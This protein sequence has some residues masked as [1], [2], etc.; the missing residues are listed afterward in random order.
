M[1]GLLNRLPYAADAPFN[2]YK[3]Q[4]DTT[5]LHNTRVDLLRQIYDWIDGA[6]GR[7]IFWLNGLAGTG[8][9]TIARTVARQC[10][11]QYRLGASF[12]FSRGG[13][14]TGHA[15][16]FFTSLALQLARKSQYLKR[17]ICDAIENSDIASQSLSEQWRQLIL[18]PLSK[19]SSSSHPSS[20]VITI[21]ALDECENKKDIQVILQLLAEAQS[22]K[23]VLIRVFLTSRPETPIRHGFN[24]ISED[25]QHDIVLHNIST[26][27]V[28]HDISVFLTY[29]LQLIGRENSL[30]NDWPGVD[31]VTHLVQRANGLFIWAATACRFVEGP[32]AEDQISMILAGDIHAESP[33]GYL[34]QLYTTVL[35][36]SIRPNYSEKVKQRLYNLLRK[37]LGSI[38]VL[39]STLSVG[40]LST[41]LNEKLVGSVIRDLHAII[42]IPKDQNQHLR[43]HHPSFRD[44]LLDQNR[45]IDL[46]FWVDEKLAHQKLMEHCIQLMSASLKNNICSAITPGTFTTEI[47]RSRVDQALPPEVQ[48]A[49]LYWTQH[50]QKSGAHIQDN[51]RVHQFLQNHFLHWLEAL[52]W[53]QKISEGIIQ[54]INLEAIT[55]VSNII[56]LRALTKMLYLGVQLS[57][58][59][60]IRSR[61]E[62]ICIA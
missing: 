33:E 38:V 22:L 27:V 62:T 8:K 26:S 12:F 37:T 40:S 54:I 50:L 58:S 11:E 59:T 51:E 39:F 13:G 4:H 21:D 16:K 3:R 30:H 20:C 42:D 18:G 48:Y 49:C 52:G 46:N 35:Q 28:N 10:F 60:E 61:Y 2:A 34:N 9:S 19:L 15:G 31:V 24:Q 32:F 36:N 56:Y 44:F 41:I 17:Y 55:A 14:D 53:M 43:L 23:N 7:F 45:C 5:C 47:E 57:R 29:N 25:K 6:D 1:D